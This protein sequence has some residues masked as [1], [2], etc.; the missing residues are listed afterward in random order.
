MSKTT[1]FLTLPDRKLAYQL[2]NEKPSKT[3][4]TPLVYLGGYAS[5]MEGSKATFLA[6]RCAAAGRR[7]LRF[8]YRGHGQSSGEFIDG[9]IGA[10]LDDALT[11]FDR[12]TEGPQ[13]LIGSSMG[14][15]MGLLLAK[16]RPGRIAG[17][18]G[19][20]AAP[21][22]TTEIILPN[23]TPTQRDQLAREGLM[24]E[25]GI[26]EE[27]R[28]PFTQRLID[29][30]RANLVLQEPLGLEA[31]VHLLQG[32][33]DIE[34]PW[35]HALKIAECLSGDDVRITFIKDGTHSLSRPQ[36]LELLWSVV[37]GMG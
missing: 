20:A 23:L 4:K 16:A 14:G 8:D 7:L 11:I 37:E 24:Y 28:V 10:W 3:G 18:V 22:F 27:Y 9:T 25:E 29:E 26:P 12:L 17:F 2:V 1:T 15:W 5:N 6:E 36:D 30:A 34:V 33:N 21:D 19:I 31:P 13:V 35:K 32:M